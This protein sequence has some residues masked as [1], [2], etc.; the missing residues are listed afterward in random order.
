LEVK[1]MRKFSGR[2]SPAMAVAFIALLAALSGTAVALPG[3]NTVD[4]GDIKKGAVKRS[5]I[6]SNAVRSKHV[7]DGSLLAKDFK[8]GQL[9]V[10]PKGDTGAPGAPGAP[11][12]ALAFAGVRGDGTLFTPASLAKNITAANISHPAT[13]V[14]C[15][16]DLP[17][18][19]RSAIASGANGFGANFTLATVEINGRDGGTFAG[20]CT[21]TDQARVRTANVPGGVASALAD[22]AFYVWFE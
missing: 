7:K 18:T 5:D 14:Y 17:F 4:S 10:G 16:H 13:G 19:P 1:E 21:A 6:A 20:E 11:G 12:E 8:A 22:L 3:K 2:P 15:F 9:P